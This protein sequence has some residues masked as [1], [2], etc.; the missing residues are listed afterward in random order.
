MGRAE[1]GDIS[2]D[3]VKGE[4]RQTGDLGGAGLAKLASVLTDGLG[5]RDDYRGSKEKRH[6]C[7]GGLSKG[8]FIVKGYF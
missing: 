1:R 7:L 4:G 8:L 6:L 3:K 5:E 2:L